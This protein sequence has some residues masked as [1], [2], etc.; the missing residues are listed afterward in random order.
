MSRKI[1]QETFDDVVKE[2][3]EEFEL[4][5]TEALADAIKQ[6]N[7]QDVDLTGIDLSGGIGRQDIL[8]AVKEL[9]EG[10]KSPINES[11]VLLAIENALALCHSEHQFSA[12]NRMFVHNKGGVN[13]LHLLLD[14]VNSSQPVIL[15]AMSFMDDLCKQNGMV[16]FMSRYFVILLSLFCHTNSFSNHF[17]KVLIFIMWV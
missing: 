10:S 7:K 14:P 11:R 15:K 13:A 6:F 16:L 5:S 4:D 8:D 3:M 12:R 2:N 9:E 17:C 1:S